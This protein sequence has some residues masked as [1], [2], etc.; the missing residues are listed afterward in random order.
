MVNALVSI[1]SVTES[2]SPHYLL[3]DQCKIILSNSA[4][5]VTM[6]S[7]VLRGCGLRAVSGAQKVSEGGQDHATHP[8]LVYF[9]VIRVRVSIPGSGGWPPEATCTSSVAQGP[10]GCSKGPPYLHRSG[11][12]DSKGQRS[13]VG[14]QGWTQGEE[15]WAASKIAQLEGSPW[16]QGYRSSIAM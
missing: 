5:R 4:G 13:P 10:R 14:R 16:V 9:C 7:T 6:T 1:S 15:Y 2:S 3:K 11:G 8:L 12:R